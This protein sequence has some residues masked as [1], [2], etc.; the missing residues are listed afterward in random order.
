MF[1]RFIQELDKY[2]MKYYIMFD[3]DTLQPSDTHLMINPDGSLITSLEE[4]SHI[5]EIVF[6]DCK[7]TKTTI[8][9]DKLT[10]L[11]NRNI[12]FSNCIFNGNMFVREKFNCYHFSNC[13]NIPW[14]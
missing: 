13:T 8:N 5:A 6:E 4:K 1:E 7:F 3:L 11:G 2:N 9:N 10:M 12:M 14:S